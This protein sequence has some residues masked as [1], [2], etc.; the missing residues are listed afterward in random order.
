M[1]SVTL[2]AGPSAH[3]VPKE[4]FRRHGIRVLPPVRRHDVDALIEGARDP[5]IV[6]ICDG[7]FESEPAVSHAELCRALDGGWAV[8]G[9]SSIGAI[10][11]FEMRT[12][13]MLGFGYVYKQFAR[14][15]DFTDDELCLLHWPGE[16]YIPLTEALVNVRYALENTS[17]RLR[18]SH[19][20][21]KQIISALRSLWFGDR[22]VQ[23]T[24]GAALE[25]GMS[26]ERVDAFLAWLKQN[27]VKTIDLVSLMKRRPWL[28]QPAPASRSRAR[29]PLSSPTRRA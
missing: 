5:G 24:L 29:R 18:I 25:T 13:G 12:E 4:F 15:E 1:P 28:D 9:V 22:T 20:Q 16:P 11:A 14:F 8:W 21:A 17:N 23:R 7:V 2:Y 10:R 6:I 27:R 26:A 19:A 3:G